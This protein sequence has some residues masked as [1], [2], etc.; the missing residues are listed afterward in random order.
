[1]NFLTDKKKKNY[2]RKYDWNFVIKVLNNEKERQE[3]HLL[4]R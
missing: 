1:M 2:E 4:S 3:W